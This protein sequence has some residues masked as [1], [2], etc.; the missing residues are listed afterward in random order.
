MNRKKF[1]NNAGVL[2]AAAVVSPSLFAAKQNVRVNKE[3]LP[4]KKIRVGLIGCGS[5]STQYLPHLSKCSYAEIVSLCDIKPERAEK[6]AQKYKV[7]SWYPHID[8]MLK[9][10]PFDLL[11][12]TT[13]MQE[14]GRLNRIAILSGKNVWCEKPL[15]NTYE[16]GKEL[17]DL[18]IKKGIRIWGAPAVVN[19]PQFTF[20]AQQINE[21]KLGRIAAAH[22]HYGHEG[23]NWSA[24]FYEKNGGSLPD[25][26]VYNIATLT[27]LFG[28]AKSVMAMTN[29]ITPT[30]KTGNKGEIKVE[31]ED[32]AQVLFDHQ[33]GVL[34]HVQCGFNYFDPYGHAGTG[35][36]KPTI[37]VYGSNANMHMI[38]YDWK[39]LG[40]DMATLEDPKTTRYLTDP[41]TYVWQEGA[42]VICECMATG[43]EPR[44]NVK[45]SLHVLEIIEA[46]RKSQEMGKRIPLKSTFTWPMI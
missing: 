20:M 22:G 31:A 14:H 27:G 21:G 33:S 28:P 4:E 1:L 3:M 23:P 6:A 30:R 45:H 43:K 44:I 32:N 26:G 34:S 11:I 17:L 13:D 7:A 40:V 2:G 29:V 35:Q 5:V 25:L 41:G 24:F 37:S 8:Q 16:E 36:E 46:S 9:G 39:P 42:S 18:A 12:N 38:G 10:V 15:A 19:S